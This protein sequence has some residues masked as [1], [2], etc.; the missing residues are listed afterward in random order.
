MGAFR[1]RQLSFVIKLTFFQNRIHERAADVEGIDLSQFHEFQKEFEIQLVWTFYVPYVHV[2]SKNWFGPFR[3]AN[4]IYFVK[5]YDYSTNNISY[6]FIL[7][8][9]ISMK[10]EISI[11]FSQKIHPI[12]TYHKGPC[13]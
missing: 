2:K 10:K 9:Y 12:E 8:T 11:P 6:L 4:N 13:F 3:R 1:S 7:V 5:I